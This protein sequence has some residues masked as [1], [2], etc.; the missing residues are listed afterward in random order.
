MNG[1]GPLRKHRARLIGV[2]SLIA[3][4]AACRPVTTTIGP[5]QG[6]ALGEALGPAAPIGRL[7]PHEGAHPTGTVRVA[8]KWPDRVV[9]GLPSSTNNVTIEVRSSRL[10]FPRSV[11][12]E[13]P[14]V[15]AYSVGSITGIPSGPINVTA[16]AKSLQ[17]TILGTAGAGLV[18]RPNEVGQ[19]ALAWQDPEAATA[20]NSM[21]PVNG[22]PGSFVSIYGEGFGATKGTAFTIAVGGVPVPT[23][24]AVR[25]SD[26][27]MVFKVP[28]AAT[29]SHVVVTV[30]TSTV[31]SATP[32]VKI[33]SVSISPTFAV[34]SKGATQSFGY[35][36]FDFAGAAVPKPSLIWTLPVQ[37]CSGC[38]DGDIG[39]VN[40]L[41]VFVVDLDVHRGYGILQLGIPPVAATANI[42]VIP[43]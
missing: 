37:A 17:G 23:A 22:F 2:A 14:Q 41:G 43:Q 31:K 15:G 12:L 35:T 32:F 10:T 3:G 16:T 42:Q 26:N 9:A 1:I 28:G 18:L 39:I 30:G 33:A 29:S 8:V 36:V 13:G 11:R 21:S 20:F 24:D 25:A 34:L 40:P 27:I 19:A 7:V 5:T 38:P 4:L 6:L